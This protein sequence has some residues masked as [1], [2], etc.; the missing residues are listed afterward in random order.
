MNASDWSVKPAPK[1]G[2]AS[3]GAAAARSRY[4]PYSAAVSTAAKRPGESS[5]YFAHMSRIWAGEWGSRRGRWTRSQSERGEGAETPPAEAAAAARPRAAAAAAAL[6]GAA[7]DP[8][9]AR[10]RDASA[11]RR[12]AAVAIAPGAAG[13][14]GGGAAGGPTKAMRREARGGGARACSEIG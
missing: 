5:W 8:A 7:L 3:S 14:S 11:A 12:E 10:A 6:A 1:A 13:G 2:S 4:R 9:S